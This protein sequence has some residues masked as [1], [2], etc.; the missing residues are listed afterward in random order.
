M[1]EESHNIVTLSVKNLHK[2]FGPVE[3]LHGLDITL[4]GG[5]VHAI[6]GEN[7]AG[8]STLV[9][10]LSGFEPLSSGELLLTKDSGEAELL[11]EWNNELAERRRSC[12][13]SSGIQSRRAAHR[14]REYFS[15]Q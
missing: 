1:S 10:I 8:K 15:W 11:T 5:E 7:G 4:R 12:S 6:L 9:K 3:V 14:G 13:N 2:S